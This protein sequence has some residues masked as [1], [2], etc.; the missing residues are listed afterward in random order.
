GKIPPVLLQRWEAAFEDLSLFRFQPTVIH[1][2]IDGES[3]MALDTQITG[4][5]GWSNL[6]IAD[7]A[8]DLAWVA[9]SSNEAAAYNVF[10]AY[11]AARPSADDKLR[12]RA[13]LYSE[14]DLARWLL[15]C[16]KLKDE[17]MV[18]EA[19][20]MLEDLADEVQQGLRGVLTDSQPVNYFTPEVGDLPEP[21]DLAN[22]FEVEDAGFFETVTVETQVLEIVE[23]PEESDAF[24]EEASAEPTAEQTTETQDLAE[25][26][27]TET[28]QLTVYEATLDDSDDEPYYYAETAEIIVTKKPDDRLF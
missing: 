3:V 27:D 4:F 2:A 5:M 21:D 18:Q 23:I 17:A 20:Q 14:F 1:G 11:H 7:P 9:G 16:M 24:T 8:E 25:P 10:L 15:H 28:E 12:I 13:K 19:S 6:K 26:L 22:Q